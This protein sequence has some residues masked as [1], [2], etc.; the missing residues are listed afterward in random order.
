MFNSSLISDTLNALFGGG[1]TGSIRSKHSD[2]KNYRHRRNNGEYQ[3][4]LDQLDHACYHLIFFLS[5]ISYQTEYKT[6]MSFHNRLAWNALTLTAF[7]MLPLLMAHNNA[8]LKK[9]IKRLEHDRQGN[10][11]SSNDSRWAKRVSSL[12][13]ANAENSHH[14]KPST[15]SMSQEDLQQ[16]KVD[17]GQPA[18]EAASLSAQSDTSQQLKGESDASES[19]VAA[20]VDETSQA[21]LAQKQSGRA[22]GEVAHPNTTAIANPY[23]APSPP[24]AY[25]P[26]HAQQ[27]QQVEGAVSEW[28]PSPSP[29][30]SSPP[31]SK[32]NKRKMISHMQSI[33]E[34]VDR[35]SSDVVVVVPPPSPAWQP[36]YEWA[37]D[38]NENDDIEGEKK[39]TL[40]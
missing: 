29:T 24:P 23:Q 38:P 3:D 32:S 26:G 10:Q 4:N 33:S 25:A 7:F 1:T 5:F 20:A 2:R 21:S 6:S 34:Y 15:L 36:Q 28:S 17:N 37:A 16:E 27:E 30:P 12:A 11:L 35:Q 40:Q 19:V 14:G 9:L 8:T 22:E 39:F 13:E 18:L 31:R